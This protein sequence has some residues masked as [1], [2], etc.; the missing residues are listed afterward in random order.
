[1]LIWKIIT[2][3]KDAYLGRKKEAAIK[4]ADANIKLESVKEGQK[5]HKEKIMARD[6]RRAKKNL[7]I[8]S[9]KGSLAAPL[10]HCKSAY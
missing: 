7:R 1:M 5:K 6:L 2:S 8:L 9:R 4:E 10:A 3:L